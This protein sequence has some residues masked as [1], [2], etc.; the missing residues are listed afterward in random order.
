MKTKLMILI[1]GL[2]IIHGSVQAQFDDLYFNP[3]ENRS[4][5]KASS[6]SKAAD[7]VY[8]YNDQDY[9]YEED[10]SDYD[11]YY[12]ARIRRFH[13]PLRGFNY[14]DP[15]YA[16]M[17]YYDPG[18]MMVMS[19][20]ASL[21]IH[22][23]P[24][25]FNRFNRW[26]PWNSW[27]AFNNPWNTWGAFNNPW[28][29]WGAFNNPWNRFGYGNPWAFGGMG[30]FNPYM[31]NWGYGGFMPAFGPGVVYN[32]NINVIDTKTY[33]GP[34]N[35]SSSYMPRAGEYRRPQAAVPVSDRTTRGNTV[36]SNSLPSERNAV[37]P[38]PSTRGYGY[39]RPNST[40][41]NVDRQ[42]TPTSGTSVY[43][44]ANTSQ[45]QTRSTYG[46]TPR[47]IPNTGRNA[48]SPS[49]RSSE[50]RS[51]QQSAPQM[52]SSGSGGY[53]SGGTTSGGGVSRSRGGGVP[54]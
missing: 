1:F 13:R 28:N 31:G 44:R 10:L 37:S 30:M 40:T 39:Q 33:Y 15:F 34:R 43:N 14:F 54:Q 12:T 3:A 9:G 49:T 47:S 48:T 24:W 21:L 22:T 23:N 52:R 41:N 18:M 8:G 35:S 2:F 36:R 45:Q 27:G 19:P 38:A 46:G 29:S 50:P 5:M 20:G 51:I 17:W 25:S 42:K 6:K 11:Y 7:D 16:D 4:T 26:S 32:T 53:S